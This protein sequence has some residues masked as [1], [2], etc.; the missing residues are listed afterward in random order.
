M[1]KIN[2]VVALQLKFYGYPDLASYTLGHADMDG[3][4]RVSISVQSLPDM[5]ED[6]IDR[7]YSLQ[8]QPVTDTELTI[9]R[10]VL[11]KCIAKIDK[12]NI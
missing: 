6:W 7:A 2:E 5:V 1:S 10:D 4:R 12:R 11:S 3:E 9:L 8:G